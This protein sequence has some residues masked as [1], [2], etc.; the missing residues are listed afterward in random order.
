[1][2]PPADGVAHVGEVRGLDRHRK[3]VDR[4]VGSRRLRLDAD[5]GGAL[6]ERRHPIVHEIDIALGEDRQREP[7]TNQHFQK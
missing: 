7:A 3:R 4:Y 6:E 1:M 5:V 2:Q